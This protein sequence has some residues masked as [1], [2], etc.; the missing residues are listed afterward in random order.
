M[1][2]NYNKADFVAEVMKATKK[3]GVDVVFEHVGPATWKGSMRCLARG[4]RLVTCGATTGPKVEL[5]LRF[6]FTKELS[7]LGCT[8]GGRRELEEVLSEVSRGRLKP[9]VGKVFALQ[10]AAQAQAT[11]ESRNF[12]GKLVLKVT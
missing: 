7:V 10:E 4:G 6:F 12:F 5:D 8:M 2:V 11:L 1:A 9:V 3:R